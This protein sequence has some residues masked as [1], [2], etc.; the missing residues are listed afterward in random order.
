MTRLTK[1]PPAAHYAEDQPDPRF[2]IV[3]NGAHTNAWEDVADLAEAFGKPL[4]EWQ[5]TV[6]R[7]AMGERRDGKWAARYVLVS[8]PRQ[9]GKSL[10]MAAR[11]VAGAL[12]LGEKKIV[13]SAHRQDTVRGIFDEIV[14]WREESP[15][16][17]ERLPE[18]GIQTALMREAL[19]FTNGSVIQ[20]KARTNNGGRGFSCD[21]LLLDEAQSLGDVAWTAINSTMSARANPQAYLFGTPPAPEDD[22]PVFTKMRASTLAGKPGKTAYLEWSADP[23]ADPALDT[24]RASANPAWHTRINHDIVDGE[25][26]SYSPEQ[27]ARERLGIWDTEEQAKK[28][29]VFDREDWETCTVTADQVPAEGGQ[30]WGVKFSTNGLHIGAAVAIKGANDVIHVE[31]LGVAPVGSGIPALVKWLAKP[32]RYRAGIIAVDGKSGAGEFAEALR[33]NGVPRHRINIINTDDAINAHQLFL[34][35]VR[36]HTLTHL[37]QPSLNEAAENA[38]FRKIGNNGG[39]GWQ[40]ATDDGDVTALDAVTLAHHQASRARRPSNR[41]G[42]ATTTRKHVTR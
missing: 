17:A 24:T 40:P 2:H 38:T 3:P 36:E 39:R 35:A 29:Q 30:G 33:K 14:A 41:T 22:A 8:A 6:L 15:A 11:A 42:R 34:R 21:C 18:R 10:L 31:S 5:L 37:G 23:E 12:V 16:L 20:F 19:K 32:E 26:A 4:D 27:F 13:I 7:A 28:W 9:N 1:L 25:F